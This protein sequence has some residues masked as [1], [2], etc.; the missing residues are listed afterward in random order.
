[1]SP[2]A[3][4]ESE[5]KVLKDNVETMGLL[6]EEAYETLFLALDQKNEAMIRK[7]LKNDRTVSDMERR[8]E[9]MCLSL[10]TKQQPVATDLRMITASLKVVTDIER[11]NN[12]VSDMAELLLR[13][14][15]NEL[16]SYSEH[17]IPMVEEAKKMVHAAVE[18]FAKREEAAAREVIAGDDIVDHLFN[19]V[20]DDLIAYLKSETKNADECIDVLMIAKYLEKIGDH[21]VN[22][23]SWQL[24]I[25]SAKNFT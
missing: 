18:A 8:I 1:M 17:I 11:V 22:I 6:V 15:M 13:I 7:I 10:I 23:A 4:F 21:A 16:S 2:R 9:S 5:L 24:F 25:R 19:K 20:K 14:N 3:I 12:H